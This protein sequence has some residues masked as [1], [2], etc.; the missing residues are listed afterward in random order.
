MLFEAHWSGLFHT[1]W[2]RWGIFSGRE[3]YNFHRILVCFLILIISLRQVLG[4]VSSIRH[5]KRSLSALKQ[6][7][8]NF[9][10]FRGNWYCN[11]RFFGGFQ[12]IDV[13]EPCDLDQI[14]IH[15]KFSKQ[16]HRFL[17]ISGWLYIFIFAL[18]LYYYFLLKWMLNH[19][20]GW[21]QVRRDYLVHLH[22]WID[23][24]SFHSLSQKATL[25]ILIPPNFCIAG[26]VISWFLRDHIPRFGL[27]LRQFF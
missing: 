13:R 18:V 3:L 19:F 15:L 9:D 4:W 10:F 6:N 12:V 2:V 16:R 25:F 22:E 26:A 23:C 24:E 21:R 5:L 11:L 1:L 8:S 14:L 17:Q 20:I 7:V 27:T